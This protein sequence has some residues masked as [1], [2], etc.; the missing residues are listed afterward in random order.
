MRACRAPTGIR[1]RSLLFRRQARYPVA[2]SGQ[3]SHDGSNAI[4]LPPPQPDSTGKGRFQDTSRRVR[5]PGS[6][7]HGSSCEKW[8]RID[9][10]NCGLLNLTNGFTV[11][12]IRPLCHATII[13]NLHHPATRRM[14]HLNLSALRSW[15]LFEK[16]SSMFTLQPFRMCIG[17]R[18]TIM[19]SVPVSAML[20]AIN[21]GFSVFRICGFQ[22]RRLASNQR[23]PRLQLGALAN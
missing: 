4:D 1:T 2:L 23:P 7:P 16:P 3:C 11:R 21:H 14:S 20:R 13:G 17:F 18:L 6:S 10:N 8:W 12:R 22:C 19:I 9:L 5:M 15:M